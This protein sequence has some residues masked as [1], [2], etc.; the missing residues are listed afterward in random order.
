MEP[1]AH[2]VI[3]R[4]IICSPRYDSIILVS[5]S[6]DVIYHHKSDILKMG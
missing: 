5:N 2:M 4:S 1:L 3:C 6:L